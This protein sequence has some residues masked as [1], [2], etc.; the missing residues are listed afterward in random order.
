[1]KR[2]SRGAD[3]G[4]NF[5]STGGSMGGDKIGIAGMANAGSSGS[6]GMAG[7]SSGNCARTRCG[8]FETWGC[9]SPKKSATPA[10]K[11]RVMT[12]SRD[13]IRTASPCGGLQPRASAITPVAIATA[14]PMRR[15]ASAS[16]KIRA[17]T[18]APT[19]MLTSRVGA[20]AVIGLNVSAHSTRM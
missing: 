13:F 11:N 6:A 7:V 4:Y 18:N 9:V 1:M 15:G 16:L 12:R 14:A 20:M 3:L 5:F 8:I 10:T 17:P 19:K 2:R